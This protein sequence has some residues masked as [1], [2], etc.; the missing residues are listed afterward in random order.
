MKKRHFE[1]ASRE[2]GYSY[3]R[4]KYIN[5]EDLFVI[6]PNRE[7]SGLLSEFREK[8]FDWKQKVGLDANT[9]LNEPP[10]LNNDIQKDKIDIDFENWHPGRQFK[11]TTLWKDK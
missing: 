6:F 3:K 7:D 4:L 5:K 8:L 11:L 9:P 10:S 2:C 1:T